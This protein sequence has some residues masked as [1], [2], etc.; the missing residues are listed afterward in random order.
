MRSRLGVIVLLLAGC[1]AREMAG[2]NTQPILHPNLAEAMTGGF[3][4]LVGRVPFAVQFWVEN[5]A[6]YQAQWEVGGGEV[7]EG[8]T[9]GGIVARFDQAGVYYPSVRLSAEGRSTVTLSQKIVVLGKPA[10]GPA[11]K[12]GVNQ[13]LAWDPPAQ[14]RPEVG[15]MKAAGVE[16]LRLPVRWSWVEPQAGRYA[17]ELQD[18]AVD[19]AEGAGLHILAVLG[20]TPAWSS[21]V[22]QDSLPTDV[23]AVAYAPR[24]TSDF[25][26]YVYE[27]VQHF[28]GRIPAYE[29]LN[30]PNSVNHWRPSPDAA[31]FV[32][33]LC[34][35]YYAAKY[36]DPSSVI[37]A[38]GLNGNGL[39]LGWEPAGSRDFLKAIYAGPG[40]NCFDVMAIHPF[41]HPTEDGLAGLQ[42]WV[43]ATRAYMRAQGDGRELWLTEVG[44]STG[45]HLWGHATISDQQQ[46]A[47]VTAVYRD[48][49]GPQKIFWYNF[50]DV[51]IPAM[52]NPEYH[53][54]WLR[55]DLTPKPAYSF[56][57]ALQK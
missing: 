21:G 49:A 9:G 55:Y 48:L 40:A 8:K 6:G 52:T 34:A 10:A 42:A 3:D 24:R 35:G 51:A 50:K 32:E 19:Q 5:G 26:R 28:R 25:A 54:G 12:Y 11:G 17:W 46:A 43:D 2:A 45:P 14:T 38:G 20:S 56:F 30:E 13:D 7:S 39:F 18:P 41:A 31:R 22:T 47:W 15:L 23:P 1:G 36:A 53:W 27:T 57:Q 37:V 29:L 44:W 33:L 4:L 16:W